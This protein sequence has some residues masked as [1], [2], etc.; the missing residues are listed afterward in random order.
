MVVHPRHGE[1][2]LSIVAELVA[3]KSFD[4]VVVD[5]VAALVPERELL[6]GIGRG[7]PN[8]LARLMSASLRSLNAALGNSS[9]ALLMVNQLRTHTFEEGGAQEVSA[10]GDALKY[11]AALRVDVRRTQ[12]LSRD[13]DHGR[14]A[15]GQRSRLLVV[16][17]KV[18][19]P[20]EH[21]DVVISFDHGVDRVRELIDVG[22]ATGQI[23]RRESTYFY[24]DTALGN[25]RQAMTRLRQSPEL[26]ARIDADVRRTVAHRPPPLTKSAEDAED[27]NSSASCALTFVSST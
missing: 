24:D 5:S 6:A 17:S 19:R 9:T 16:K 12:L 15:V 11:Y 18:G 14:Q 1:E 27:L 20:M 22:L 23:E 25:H 13:T 7:P 10:G 8:Q 21:V 2:A 3:S 26:A 4:L